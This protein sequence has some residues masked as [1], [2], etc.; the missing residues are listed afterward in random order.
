MSGR[1]RIRIARRR[2]E[3]VDGAAALGWQMR[4]AGLAPVSEFRFHPTR[5]WRSDY[6]FPDAKLLIEFEGGIWTGGAHV[7]GKH[8]ESDC[9]KY[10]AA[11]LLG[12]RVLRFSIDMVKSGRALQAIEQALNVS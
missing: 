6:A 4:A 12:Y 7:R 2:K 5:M 8:F 11:A 3:K 1:A 9:E 10:N